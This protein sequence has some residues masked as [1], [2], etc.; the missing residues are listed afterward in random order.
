MFAR[1]RGWGCDICVNH[2]KE[3]WVNV[4][5]PDARWWLGVGHL[6]FSFDSLDLAGAGA[7][8]Y[9]E[10]SGSVGGVNIVAAAIA[11]LVVARFGLREGQR[12]A[13]WFLAFS[14]L[15]AGLHDLV[16]AARFF[17]QTGQPLLLMPLAYCALMLIGLLKSR[18]AIFARSAAR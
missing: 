2:I 8:P 7:A 11:V 17:A 18:S 5:R 6:G 4:A 10:L 15:W 9:V 14:L 16:M 13:F 1:N 3:S 12:W